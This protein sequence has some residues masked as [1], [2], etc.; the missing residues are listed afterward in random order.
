M[1]FIPGH[2]LGGGRKGPRPPFGRG[3]RAR[4]N[5]RELR[6]LGCGGKVQ[7]RGQGKERM[8]RRKSDVEVSCGGEAGRAGDLPSVRSGSEDL[9]D[10]P[11]APPRI[12]GGEGVLDSWDVRD[13]R[14]PGRHPAAEAA[15]FE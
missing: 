10:R 11:G 8:W 7:R 2:R 15:R 3:E 1:E 5:D 12:A 13:L 14:G 6:R 4:L 9:C